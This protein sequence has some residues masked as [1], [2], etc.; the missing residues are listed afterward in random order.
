MSNLKRVGTKVGVVSAAAALVVLQALPASAATKN[1]GARDC[2]SG[3]PYVQTFTFSNGTTVH[4]QVYGT[5]LPKTFNNGA[6]I[7]H[8]YWSSGY[9]QVSASSATTDG[10]FQS[11]GNGVTCTS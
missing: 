7:V 9:T 2:G 5:G 4:L 3:L 10:T 6:N 11:S 1:F 8:R